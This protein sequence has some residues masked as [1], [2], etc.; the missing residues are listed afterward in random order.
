V[1]DQGS[2]NSGNSGTSGTPGSLGEFL[3]QEREKRGITIEQ[4]ASATKI[5]V[6]LLHLLESDQ[7]SELPAKPFIRGFVSSYAR[8]I[9]VDSK[10]I[11]THFGDFLE[12]RSH[13]RPTRDAGHSGYAFEKR[14]GEQ[15]RTIL[16]IVM[17]GFLVFGGIGLIFLKPS[18]KR[19]K[20]SQIEKLRDAN[21]ETTPI[22][23]PSTLPSSLPSSMPSESPSQNP[24]SS[25]SVSP[26]ATPSAV[27]VVA[28]PPTPTHTPTPSP[29][30]SPSPTP[31]ATPA[32][33][34]AAP[35]IVTPTPSPSPTPSGA[36][37][38]EKPDL[39]NSGVNLAPADIKYKIVFKAGKDVWVRYQIDDRAKMKF[40]LREGR[41]LVLHAKDSVKFQTSDP[42]SLTFRVNG[43]QS[44]VMEGD[45]NAAVK[46]EDLTLFFPAQLIETTKEVFPGEKALQGALVPPPKSTSPT[47]APAD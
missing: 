39:L 14:E 40:I 6:R 46:G 43:A 17:G 16:W 19:H 1:A 20:S 24:S 25:S 37:K 29:C 31:M 26:S 3:R 8:F 33:V 36:A 10:E 13:E 4:V 2:S 23:T 21:P 47:A 9:G 35:P 41:I 30:P 38:E 18:L 27:A 12:M 15:S 45:K 7:Y 5:N 32:A 22:E 34:V 44:R 28:P 11:L 42:G